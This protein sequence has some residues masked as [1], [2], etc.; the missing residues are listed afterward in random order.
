[1]VARF[2]R[3]E[4][5]VGSNPVTS[6]IQKND[7]LDLSFFCI[8]NFQKV[9]CMIDINNWIDIFLKALNDTFGDRVWFVGL[10]GSYARG[11]ADDTSDIDVVVILDQLSSCDIKSYDTMLNSLPCRELTCGFLSGRNE[12]LS[13]ELSDVIQLYYDTRPIKGSLDDLLLLIDDET[14]LRTVKIGVCN[15][16]HGC[17]HN[18]LYEKSDCILKSL[19][20]NATFVIQ[21]KHFKDKREYITHKKDLLTQIPENDKIIL[22]TYI[23]LRQKN[24]IRFEEMSETLFRWAQKLINEV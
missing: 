8:L 13:W 6:T 21:A 10:Q 15:I 22:E 20:K 16:Y 9:I 23:S 18:M 5:V 19:Y 7:K 4:E 1:M 3:D 12:L 14:I 2:V 24:E 11:E 17:V